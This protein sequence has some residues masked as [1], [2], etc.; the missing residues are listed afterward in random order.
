MHLAPYVSDQCLQTCVPCNDRHC[1]IIS[2]AVPACD[3]H[4]CATSFD[5]WVPHIVSEPSKRPPINHGFGFG[6]T[7]EKFAD[8][9]AN[10]ESVTT[11]K[12]IHVYLSDNE[13]NAAFLCS[14]A[15]SKMLRCCIIRN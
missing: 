14:F 9:D 5:L 2:I 3:V 4:S 15:K 7:V 10:S 13:L 6:R 1:L 12:M 8:S 11:L